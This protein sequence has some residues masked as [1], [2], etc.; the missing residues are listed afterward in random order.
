MIEEASYPSLSG[1][2]ALVTG[3]AGGIGQAICQRLAGQGVTLYAGD[4]KQVSIPTLD[5][6]ISLE[7]DVTS[8]EDWA[9]AAE[10]IRA[11][12][13]VLDILVNNAGIYAP[14]SLEN[15]TGDGFRRLTDINQFGVFWGMKSA[16]PLMPEGG[17]IV[18]LSSIGGMVGYNGTF[19]YAA[20]KWAVRGMTRSAARE[21][22]PRRI[23]VNSICPGVIDTPMFYENDP[24]Q[25]ATFRE[26]V[27]LGNLGKPE[28]I[29]NAVAFLASDEAG[30]ITG[31]DLL[32]D[33]GMLA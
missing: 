30:Y 16:A 20:S 10:R 9:A 21:L 26:T 19:G 3:A 18:N 25:L 33:G 8:T 1:R 11:D 14:A 31:T 13:R 4:L 7:L 22:A 28:D 12:G 23:R 29:A 6:L 2:T 32:V 15:E 24:A 5:G 17:A 27:P